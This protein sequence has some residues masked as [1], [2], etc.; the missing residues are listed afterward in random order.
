MPRVKTLSRGDAPPFDRA[1][2]ARDA[3][4]PSDQ[5]SA[6]ARLPGWF[7]NVDAVRLSRARLSRARDSDDDAREGVAP[8]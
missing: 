7:S 2:F 8:R 5:K 3:V 4:V 1:Q 6:L